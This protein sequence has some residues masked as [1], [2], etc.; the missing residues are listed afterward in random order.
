MNMIDAKR[1]Q[2]K[3]T[4]EQHGLHCLKQG[5]TWHIVGPHV[6]ISMSDLLHFHPRD[7]I[8]HYVAPRC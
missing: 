8:G 4:I 6:D 5:N 2:I 3:K 7:L 1:E